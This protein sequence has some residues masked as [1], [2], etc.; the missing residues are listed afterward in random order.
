V[1]TLRGHTDVVMAVAFS[2]DGRRL[3]SASA[4]GTIRVWNGTPLAEGAPLRDRP[5]QGHEGPVLGLAFS[6]D[7]RSLATGVLDGTARVWEVA[8]RRLVYTLPGQDVPSVAFHAGGRRLTTVATDGTLAQWDPATG[9]RRRILRGHL[10][11]ILNPNMGVGFSADGQRL[12]TLSK[13]GAVHV[14]ET[15]S[16]REVV[17]IAP[18]ALVTTAFLSPDGRRLAVGGLGSVQILEVA[19]QK[20]LAGWSTSS[21]HVLYHLAFSADGQQVAAAFGDGAVCVWEIQSEK[22][23]HTFRHDDRVAC[24]AFHPNGKQLASGS[25]DNTAK[26]WDLETGQEVTTLRGHIGYVMALA[27]SPDGSLLAT[28]RGHRYAGDVQLWVRAAFGKKR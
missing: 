9:E 23:L 14:W 15:D 20:R 26:V 28:A 27:Y 5:L 2:A 21:F 8:A 3:F 11:P 25:C 1:L 19:S 16:G 17:R 6:P 18:P 24:V 10:G 13:D 4:D 22:L 12:T 7:G